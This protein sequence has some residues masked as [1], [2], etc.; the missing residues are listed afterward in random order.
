MATSGRAITFSGLTVAIGLFGMLFYQGTFLSSMGISGAIVVASAVFYGLTFLPALLAIVGRNLGRGRIPIFQPD[1]AGTGWWHTI[2]TTV[3]RRPLVVLVP[4]V[5]FILLLGSPFLHLRLANNDVTALPTHE[6]SRA[7]FDRLVNEF[8][9]GNQTNISVVVESPTGDPLAPAH[10][11]GLVDLAKKL[12]EL[13]APANDGSLYFA[14]DMHDATTDMRAYERALDLLPT[15]GTA[16]LAL[17]DLIRRTDSARAAV[18]ILVQLLEADPYELEALTALGR[19]LLEDGRTVH[20]WIG[21]APEGPTLKNLAGIAARLT[22][23]GRICLGDERRRTVHASRYAT[24]AR[25]ARILPTRELLQFAPERRLATLVTFAIERHAALTDLAVEMF[26]KLVGTAR[27][28]A[29]RR[30]EDNLLAQAKALAV[31]ARDH[32]LARRAKIN[33]AE[34]LEHDFVGLDRASALQRFLASKAVRSGRPLRLRVQLRSFDAVCR[35]VECN[36]GIGIVP[37]T[38]AR[39][40]QKTMTI[41]IVPLTDHWAVRELTICIRKMVELPLYARQLVEHL[42]DR[43]Q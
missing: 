40:V 29:D 36:V 8:P 10:I 28:T 42:R 31:V 5:A 13:G 27:R 39:R 21:E 7:A 34:V 30:H 41:A 6:E 23:L 2:A 26:D 43:N 33:F 3:M 11:T 9:G 35:L 25:E 18:P 37:E 20:G 17:A 14:V 22:V 24:L 32:A 38:T 1:S 16:A 12:V 4:I 15:Y 19:A